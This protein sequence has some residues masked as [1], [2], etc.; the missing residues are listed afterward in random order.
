LSSALL[1]DSEL[2]VRLTALKRNIRATAKIARRY[3]DNSMGYFGCRFLDMAP[4]DMRFLFEYLYGK[5]FTD[6]DASFMA[7]Q[8]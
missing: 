2:A 7:G 3:K 1:P 6:T 8:V 5:S 4:E